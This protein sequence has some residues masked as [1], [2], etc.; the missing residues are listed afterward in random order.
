M[1]DTEDDLFEGAL[2]EGESDEGSGEADEAPALQD[3]AKAE[4]TEDP[5][6]KRIRDLMS[7]LQRTEAENN[8]LKGQKQDGTK[9]EATP[10]TTVDPSTAEMQAYLKETVQQRIFDEDPRLR[11]FGFGVEDIAGD[12][13]AAM[14]ANRKKLQAVIEKA[15]SRG[16]NAAFER[17]GLDPSVAGGPQETRDFASMSDKEIAELLDKAVGRS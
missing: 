16:L 10:S 14:R 2:P 3:D 4:A 11:E 7:Q 9:K 15:E 12:D 17:M 5:K 13:L 1:A 6:D 8:R